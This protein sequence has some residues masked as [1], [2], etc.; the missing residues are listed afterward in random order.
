MELLKPNDLFR[1]TSGDTITKRNLYDLIQFSKVSISQYWSGTDFI[2]GNTPQQG[3]NWM[4]TLPLLKAVI[5]KTKA[6]SYKEDGW[7]DDNRTI[8]NY[9]FKAKDGI[10][11][12]DEKANSVLINQPQLLYPIL[13]FTESKEG[14]V[15]EGQFSVTNIEDTYVVLKRNSTS[16]FESQSSL[17]ESPS[18]DSEKMYINHLKAERSKSV[19]LALKD[20]NT[21]LCEI[22]NIDYMDKYNIPYIEAHFKNRIT[23][24]PADQLISLNDH[25]L[26]CPNCHKAVH[27]V[28]KSKD[29][30][31][32]Q[33]KSN[34]IKNYN[35]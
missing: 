6:G 7:Y 26:L 11:S 20:S 12:Y 5:I 31:Y 15:F 13:L 3:I 33:I 1:L 34:L 30:D 27:V 29:L 19:L 22:C 17:D 35:R 4:G 23:G 28:M 2:I 10:I 14:W 9:S 21:F 24:D 25:A 32:Y 16:N 18:N 8:Y